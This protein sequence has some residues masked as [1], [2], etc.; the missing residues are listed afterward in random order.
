MYKT[1]NV[2]IKII[3]CDVYSLNVTVNNY[4]IEIHTVMNKR[5][6]NIFM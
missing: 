4:N 5:F 6:L 1:L 3:N 2:N